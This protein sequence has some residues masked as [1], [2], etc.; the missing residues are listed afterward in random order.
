MSSL[1]TSVY[2]GKS[3]IISLE[4]LMR[5]LE[6]Q[7]GI[8]DK[9]IVVDEKP[10]ESGE[11]KLE[12][13]KFKDILT[14][15]KVLSGKVSNKSFEAYVSEKEYK[16]HSDKKVDNILEKYDAKTS[17][18]LSRDVSVK[19]RTLNLRPYSIFK[20]REKLHYIILADDKN[21]TL[22]KLVNWIFA[23]YNDTGYTIKVLLSPIIL[24]ILPASIPQSLIGLFSDY[25]NPSWNISK[26]SGLFS[27][28]AF[29]IAKTGSAPKG[30][31]LR[32]F[33]SDKKLTASEFLIL[34]I[35]RFLLTTSQKYREFWHGQMKSSGLIT[36]ASFGRHQL[37]FG[38]FSKVLKKAEDLS[39]EFTPEMVNRLRNLEN[40]VFTR[41]VFFYR[42]ALYRKTYMTT[43]KEVLRGAYYYVAQ[44]SGHLLRVAGMA[45]KRSK[46][47]KWRDWKSTFVSSS[48]AESTAIDMLPCDPSIWKDTASSARY[49][50][51]RW[52]F[53]K[54]SLIDDVVKNCPL[55]NKRLMTRN[56]YSERM[57]HSK[58]LKNAEPPKKVEVPHKGKPPL[59]KKPPRPIRKKRTL[60]SPPAGKK[61]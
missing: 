21:A 3:T 28:I 46:S 23:M 41:P 54:E 7:R 15:T 55:V 20:L 57:L 60:V 18:E 1:P 45:K 35:G 47:V 51:G 53:L 40:E 32:E 58:T 29:H 31:K 13:A 10:G 22:G 33:T 44:L 11:K 8:V 2:Q 37:R 59:K 19:R 25:Y 17:N 34:R 14:E 27:D 24:K 12:T 9:T 36:K 52:I 48:L 4:K 49:I 43:C 30:K 26:L 5:Y 6:S 39:K 50:D 42:N 38:T 61:S 56:T 16:L